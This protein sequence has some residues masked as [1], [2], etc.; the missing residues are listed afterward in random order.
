MI[1]VNTMKPI[2]LIVIHLVVFA[3]LP[4]VYAQDSFQG[5]KGAYEQKITSMEV[6]RAE[7]EV[8]TQA[9][10]L[11]LLD[12]TLQQ[13]KSTGNLPAYLKAEEFAEGVRSGK[14]GTPPNPV[15]AKLM[16]AYRVEIENDASKFSNQEI[17]LNKRYTTKLK[18][19]IA[20]LMK[21]DRMD[22]AKVAQAELAAIETANEAMFI[23]RIHKRYPHA[24]LSDLGEFKG[25]RYLLLGIGLGFEWGKAQEISDTL[26]GQ[27]VHIANEDE[28]RFVMEFVEKRAYRIFLR[29]M[30]NIPYINKSL[31]C[32]GHPR[33]QLWGDVVTFDQKSCLLVEWSY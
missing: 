10:F 29:G 7:A 8:Q 15:L 30:G 20:S 24:K 16:D 9:T 32:K 2:S 11:K 27:I 25:S 3:S 19:L 5:L 1:N 13:I 28:K 21:A 14:N 23:A 12:K 33:K 31:V 26:G 22:E 18:Q 4:A 17:L 6:E